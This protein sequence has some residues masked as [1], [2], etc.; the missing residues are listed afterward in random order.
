[1]MSMRTIAVVIL[2]ISVSLGVFGYWGINTAAGRRRFD[3]M[4]GMIPYFALIAAGVL[5]LI[6][7]PLLI[8]ALNQSPPQD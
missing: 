1:M 7:V 3:E 2:V 5:L 8:Y 4:A 6:G